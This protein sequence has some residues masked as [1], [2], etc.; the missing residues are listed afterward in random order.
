MEWFGSEGT[1]QIISVQTPATHW[2]RVQAAPSLIQVDASRNSAATWTTCAS[3]LMLLRN[4]NPFK[5]IIYL[6]TIRESP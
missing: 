2:E 5:S 3:I 1:L 4:E 6:K